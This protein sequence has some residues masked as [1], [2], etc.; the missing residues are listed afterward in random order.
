MGKSAAQS[1]EPCFTALALCQSQSAQCL[2]EVMGAPEHLCAFELVTAIN[3]R[4][5]IPQRARSTG[6]GAAR[7]RPR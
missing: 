5:I 3:S 1:D 7:P 6:S 4:L 2:A